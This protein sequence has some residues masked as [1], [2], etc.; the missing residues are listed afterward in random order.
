MEPKHCTCLKPWNL[1]IVHALN[2][3]PYEMCDASLSDKICSPSFLLIL[4]F[5]ADDRFY[6]VFFSSLIWA[7]PSS[8]LIM[9]VLA[10]FSINIIYI[11]LCVWEY[12]CAPMLVL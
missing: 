8:T 7:S 11:C 12:I 1:N 4:A 10:E 2:R 9:Q 6:L 5:F 3:G